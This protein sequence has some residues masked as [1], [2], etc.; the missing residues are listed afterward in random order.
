VVCTNR[1]YYETLQCLYFNLLKCSP[2]Q[3]HLYVIANRVGH[4]RTFMEQTCAAVNSHTTPVD[5][6][7]PP[8]A[9]SNRHDDV[10]DEAGHVTTTPS[11]R[12]T[13]TPLT[14][15]T[16]DGS[17]EDNS[18]D[19]DTSKCSRTTPGAPRSMSLH[20]SAVASTI[21]PS[22]TSSSISSLIAAFICTVLRRHCPA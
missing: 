5:R 9:T 15:R 14:R 6:H 3:P 16:K 1:E 22:S 4:L 12:L 2:D 8:E 11:E 17:G 21:T 19:G 20:S 7:P 18:S 10:I 13:T